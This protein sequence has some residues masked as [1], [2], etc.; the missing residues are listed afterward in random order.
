VKN[1]SLKIMAVAVNASLYAVLGYFTYFGIFV[2]GVRFWPA[3]IVPGV[4]SLV[5][6][7]VVGGL[8]AA[9]GI[10]VSDVII[11]G[12]PFLSLTVGV[13]ANFIGFYIIGRFASSRSRSGIL[14]GVIAFPIALSI[15][16][17]SLYV[18]G[19]TDISSSIT[20]IALSLACPAT[21][22]LASRYLRGWENY[23]LAAIAGLGV[24]SLIIGL[25]VW[26]Y[27]QLF[28]MPKIL[29][30]NAPLPLYMS[31]VITAWTFLSEIP[32]LIF[33]VPPIVKAVGGVFPWLG[34][35][36]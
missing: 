3:V 36:R 20:G 13:P 28:V 33:L 10:F 26:G 8:G 21:Y 32:F 22:F 5:F 29:G 19:L 35:A 34:V 6:D 30:I 27:S 2:G 25:G 11:H 12:D 1:R 16:M 9:I 14:L 18:Y 15:L 4:F 7:C 23:I 17:I 24:G 31:I